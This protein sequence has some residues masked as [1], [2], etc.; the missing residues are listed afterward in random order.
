MRTTED[1][2]VRVEL[3]WLAI[4][5][6]LGRMGVEDAEFLDLVKDYARE[7]AVLQ[8]SR[9]ATD[10]WREAEYGVAR[11]AEA[12]VTKLAGEDR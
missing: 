3:T 1:P 2:D 7:F 12:R 11:K 4:T 5:Q 6:A 10:A 9:I 8:L